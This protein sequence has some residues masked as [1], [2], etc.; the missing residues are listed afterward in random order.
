MLATGKSW[1]LPTGCSRR[2]TRRPRA[3]QRPPSPG[4]GRARP[5]VSAQPSAEREP[6]ADAQV[7]RT[8]VWSRAS[9]FPENEAGALRLWAP[10]K[11]TGGSS[12]PFVSLSLLRAFSPL[13]LRTL[14]QPLPLLFI[15]CFTP[16]HKTCCG[17]RGRLGVQQPHRS[18]GL[19]GS[20][21]ARHLGEEG[22]SRRRKDAFLAA[23]FS[24]LLMLF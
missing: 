8:Q 3:V 17:E 12:V 19:G 5:R 4:G 16:E 7:G 23:G 15:V 2:C 6:Y 21:R 22:P 13:R 11:T 9:L 18:P 10:F 20:A 24:F 1:A 14:R